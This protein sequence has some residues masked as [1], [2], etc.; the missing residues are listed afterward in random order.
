[1]QGDPTHWDPV[2]QFCPCD[3]FEISS[4]TDIDA[5][6]LPDPANIPAMQLGGETDREGNLTGQANPWLS[7][8]GDGD[9]AIW[10]SNNAWILAV[11]T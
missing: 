10:L 6:D 5:P 2:S 1:M 9:P 3:V 7:W 11:C 8:H 4:I